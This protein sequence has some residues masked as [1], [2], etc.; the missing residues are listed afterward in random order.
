VDYR[1]AR[2][3]PGE[4]AYDRREYIE[5][6]RRGDAGDTFL[7]CPPKCLGGSETRTKQNM[8]RGLA[9]LSA[10]W[11]K[12]EVLGT[13]L[14]TL[15]PC[16]PPA[17]Q[18]FG[19]AATHCRCLAQ[20]SFLEAVPIDQVPRLVRPLVFALEELPLIVAR[21]LIAEPM[22]MILRYCV[23]V[24]NQLDTLTWDRFCTW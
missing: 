23:L 24:D 4:L 21:D 10:P 7:E 15:G 11:A 18:K 17:V 9:K 8:V 14:S 16:I 1:G 12:N 3:V 22:C 6:G 20:P 2:R 13:V 19:D 5:D